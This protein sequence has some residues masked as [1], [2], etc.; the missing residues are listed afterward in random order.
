MRN[1]ICQA[2]SVIQDRFNKDLITHYEA[3][4]CDNFA[5]N[6]AAFISSALNRTRHSIYLDHVMTIDNDGLPSLQTDPSII[7][8]A[9]ND[10]FQ[11]IAGLPPDDFTPIEDMTPLWKMHIL[12]FNMLHHGFMITF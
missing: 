5:T 1:T 6:K 10:H 3:L 8:Q 11:T 7:K 4:R 9:V 12:Q 2:R